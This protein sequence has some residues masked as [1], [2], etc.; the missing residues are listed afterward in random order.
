MKNKTNV[1]VVH[2]KTPHAKHYYFSFD[3][4]GMTSQRSHH[5]V[6]SRFFIKIAVRGKKNKKNLKLLEQL[7]YSYFLLFTFCLFYTDGFQEGRQSR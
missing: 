2:E 7:L 3:H 5:F 4:R 1:A 6:E